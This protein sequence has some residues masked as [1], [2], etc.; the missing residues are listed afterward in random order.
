[1]PHDL[2][3]VKQN[4]SARQFVGRI[5][6]SVLLGFTLVAIVI[7]SL[8]LYNVVNDAFGG[9]AMQSAVPLAEITGSA[10]RPIEE[11]SQTEL[12]ALLEEELR[13]RVLRN[14]EREQPLAERSAE[15]L[16]E[17]VNAEI[18]KPEVVGLYTLS[19][20]LFNRAEIEAALLE[21][22]PRAELTFRSWVSLDFISGTASSNP[23]Q[24]GVRTAI[25]G[26]L[27]ML[28][29]TMLVA[30]PLGVGAAIYLE[31]YSTTRPFDERKPSGRF[32]NNSLTWLSN[33]IQVNIYNLSGVPSIIYGILGLA[34]FVRALETFTSGRLFGDVADATANGRTII[35]AGL[36]MA[37]LVLPVVIISSQEAIRAVPQ[38]IRQASFG[39][40]ATRWQTILR[41]VLPNALPGI[42][43]GT[44][45]AVSRAVGETAPLIVVGAST[46]INVDPDSV[47]SKFTA[48]PILIYNW[49]SRPQDEF[50]SIAAAAII[51]LLIILLSLNAL[52]IILRNYL[53]AQ[54]VS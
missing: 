24:A 48:L 52:A 27:W 49:T 46:F 41:V 33:L 25:F 23:L 32:L 54:R 53:R 38:S 43:T 1:M 26:S 42:L 28:L 4:V 15:N 47:F 16:I 18:F 51:V 14:L 40:G 9:V 50:R 8:L 10:D 19:E 39:L 35:S 12:V 11:L 7:L 37:L 3:A 36:T 31:E 45:L 29:V 44:I 13:S 5:W 20:Y 2:D 6:Q 21:E 17:I 30:F 34:I 22:F